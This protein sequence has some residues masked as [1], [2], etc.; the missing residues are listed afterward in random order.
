MG[1]ECVRHPFFSSLLLPPSLHTTTTTPTRPTIHTHTFSFPCRRR[2]K[3][4]L[5]SSAGCA[6]TCSGRPSRS[7][8]WMTTGGFPSPSSP[9]WEAAA[10]AALAALAAAAASSLAA[11]ACCWGGGWMYGWIGRVQLMNGYGTVLHEYT[12][13]PASPSPYTHLRPRRLRRLH[14]PLVPSVVP[15]HLGL[16]RLGRQLCCLFSSCVCVCFVVCG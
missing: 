3:S 9:S 1:E 12:Y 5:R 13:A 16:E 6:P 10:A 8:A 2:R 14:E 11:C 7:I 15:L 4:S